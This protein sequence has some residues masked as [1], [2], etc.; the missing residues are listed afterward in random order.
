[1]GEFNLSDK[2]FWNEK[3][4]GVEKHSQKRL[5]VKDVKKFIEEIKDKFKHETYWQKLCYELD[6]F[7]GE[8]LNEKS[9]EM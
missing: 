5:L 6:K 2:V 9:K 7:A 8:E 4:L 1:M 3:H